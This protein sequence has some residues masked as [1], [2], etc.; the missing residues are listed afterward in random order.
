MQDVQKLARLRERRQFHLRFTSTVAEKLM[1]PVARLP[2]GPLSQHKEEQVPYQNLVDLPDSVRDNLPEHAQDIYL[3]A[4]N[5]A[6]DQYDSPD[7]RRGHA[8]REETA[9]KVAWSAVRKV[10]EKNDDG[11]WMRK[12]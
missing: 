6:W 10:Y 12:S 7:E 3:E 1:E 9:H 2:Q 11:R 8:S 5:S 4:F